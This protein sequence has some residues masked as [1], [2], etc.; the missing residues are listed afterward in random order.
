MLISHKWILDRGYGKIHENQMT[1]NCPCRI[2]TINLTIEL[3]R[4]FQQRRT[5][6]YR[7]R[8]HCQTEYSSIKQ[9]TL[10]R[11]SYKM[12]SLGSNGCSCLHQ[13]IFAYGAHAL[14]Q[15]TR[16][17]GQKIT[18][19]KWR[20]IPFLS[21]RNRK[22]VY[23]WWHTIYWWVTSRTPGGGESKKCDMKRQRKFRLNLVWFNVSI[24]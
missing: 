16:A 19:R 1:F 22:H 3:L 23:C 24:L 18:L 20:H 21:P 12:P 4:D 14:R 17:P 7:Q 6:L 2:H 15:P 11:L 9:L 13:A 10:M 8:I 5:L